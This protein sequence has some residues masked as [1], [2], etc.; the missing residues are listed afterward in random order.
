MD[1]RPARS[2]TE[3]TDVIQTL[4]IDR[5]IMDSQFKENT[6]NVAGRNCH[7]HAGSTSPSSKWSK[8]IPSSESIKNDLVTMSAEIENDRFRQIHKVISSSILAIDD[9]LDERDRRLP[10]A[11][12]S[13]M[14]IVNESVSETDIITGSSAENQEMKTY[15]YQSSPHLT[16]SWNDW[17]ADCAQI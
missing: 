2:T 1:M 16:C 11:P 15:E 5:N 4:S 14:A 3:E 9:I 6:G 8:G 13:D 12:D 7:E 10:P 17:C